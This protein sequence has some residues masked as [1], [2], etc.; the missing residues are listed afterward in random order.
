M[1]ETKEILPAELV[2]MD[3]PV[4]RLV[5]LLDT[6]RQCDA[7]DWLLCTK[8]PELFFDRL[9]EVWASEMCVSG[10][11]PLVDWV[12]RWGLDGKPPAHVWVLASVENQEAAERRI[13]ELLKIPAVVRGLSLEPL[14]GPVDVSHW[15]TPEDEGGGIDWL[16]IGGESG[17]GARLCNVQWIRDLVRQGKNA[18]VAVHVKQLGSRAW[19]EEAVPRALHVHAI[20]HP[21][22]GD[23]AEWPE[24]L[25][26][27]EWPV[28]GVGVTR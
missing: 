9:R 11:Q 23:P 26:V 15:L 20:K 6:I 22:G 14:L 27:R 17:P 1:S 7:V 24:D 16:V 8:R 25:R 12:R 2:D 4:E 3:V 10:K 13:P 21:K 19:H 28:A 5:V 18:G